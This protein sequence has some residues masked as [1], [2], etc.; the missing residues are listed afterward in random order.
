MLKMIS[1]REKTIFGLTV[2]ILL[3][4][5]IF[6]FVI[7]PFLTRIDRLN[8][9]VHLTETKLRKYKYLLSRSDFIKQKYAKLFSLTKQQTQD[10]S[11]SLISTLSVLE[12]TAQNSQLKIIDIRPHNP[13]SHDIYKEIMIELRTEGDM[14][15]YLTFIY[16]LRYSPSLFK[17][18]RLILTAKPN[19]QE[20][21]ASLTVSQIAF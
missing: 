20:L 7:L 1:P 14:Q 18:K 15:A 16:N 9:E 2:A 10:S 5:C 3:L 11:D 6:N 19:S 4:S 12:S 21:D 8:K 13:K 17:I